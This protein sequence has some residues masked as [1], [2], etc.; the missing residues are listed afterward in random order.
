MSNPN[1]LT[2]YV[3]YQQV[4]LK[5]Y[6]IYKHIYTYYKLI[7]KMNLAKYYDQFIHEIFLT[8]LFIV[9][10]VPYLPRDSLFCWKIPCSL[11]FLIIGVFC[12]V[13]IIWLMGY[14]N[15]FPNRFFWLW[16]RVILTEILSKLLTFALYWLLWAQQNVS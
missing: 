8:H 5:I 1:N 2:T 16:I 7:E 3:G 10:V 13:I 15:Q 11:V 9:V 14:Q 6:S 12:G 4:Q